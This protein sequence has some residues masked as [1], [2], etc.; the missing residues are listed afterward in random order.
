MLH[1]YASDLDQDLNNDNTMYTDDDFFGILNEDNNLSAAC[2][3]TAAGIHLSY[4]EEDGTLSADL[5]NTNVISAIEKL[6]DT[7]SNAKRKDNNSTHTAF[8]E[9]RVV[10]FM[11]FTAAGY[12]RYRGMES[13]YMILPLP[14]FDESQKSYISMMNTYMSPF[15]AVPNTADLERAGVIMEAMAFWSM[16]DLRTAGFDMALK[17]KGSRNEKDSIMLDTIVNAMYLDFNAFMEFGN[18]ITPIS[19]AI[20]KKSEYVSAAEKVKNTLDKAIE[21]F[22]ASWINVSE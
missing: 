1:E 17:E 19:N 20:Y 18:S 6:S 16:D 3:M 21:K 8:M 11:H 9:D 2:F 12:N 14:K 22:S 7:I 13:D 5:N 15:V 4:I 10:F